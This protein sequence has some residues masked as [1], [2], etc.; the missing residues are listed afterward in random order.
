M[1]KYIS[2]VVKSWGETSPQRFFL[3]TT[4]V[5]GLFF[6]F[7]TP[8]FQIA[9]EQAH[10][11]RAWQVSQ[12]IFYHGQ[13]TGD[14]PVALVGI[15]KKYGR[16]PF[17]KKEKTTAKEL[18]DDIRFYPRIN[19]NETI[20]IQCNA[21]P[22]SPVLY[23]FS[24]SGFWL[25]ERADISAVAAI[26]L[27]RI[28]NLI[29]WCVLIYIAL[30]ALPVFKEEITF[31]ALL[32][33]ALFQ[34]GSLSADSVNN[35]LSFLAICSIFKVL[36]GGRLEMRDFVRASVATVLAAFCKQI[37]ALPVFLI[38]FAR[39]KFPGRK[40]F[41]L[42]FGLTC[43][44]VA[45]GGIWPLMNS[46]PAHPDLQNK[47]LMRELLASWYT[48]LVILGK[49]IVFKLPQW[50]EQY[51]GY[52]GWLDCRLPKG[53]I[54]SYCLCLLVIL[55][56]QCKTEKRIS[57]NLRLSA[58]V[59]FLCFAIVQIFA[60]YFLWPMGPANIIEG[61]QGRYFIPIMP[62]LLLVFSKKAGA[63]NAAMPMP[64]LAMLCFWPIIRS[65]TWVGLAVSCLRL[66]GRYF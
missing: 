12:G 55:I 40:Q 32:P 45:L 9:D 11:Y 42:Y 62:L 59:L 26:Y 61:I 66:W 7:L 37:G 54:L 21:F 16:I 18:V 3:L 43:F 30:R 6:I 10:A 23:I 15:A 44:A 34:A 5:F 49:T 36:V 14:I 31:L 13:M 41:F 19:S 58:L 50:T 38:L 39:E 2:P 53:I 24:A 27:A 29:A 25:A 33:M 4:A 57:L 63:A 51:F 8:P 64:S 1:I 65:L 35:A 46:L 47:D 56:T 22:Y 28:F 52:L 60:L 17:H 48:P 20:T